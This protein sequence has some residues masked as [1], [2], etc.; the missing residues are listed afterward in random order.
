MSEI[1]SIEYGAQSTVSRWFEYYWTDQDRRILPWVFVVILFGLISVGPGL[2]LY[3]VSLLPIDE[4]GNSGASIRSHQL[5]QLI[6]GILAISVS[7]YV[8]VRICRPALIELSQEGIKK[9]WLI[10][11]LVKFRGHL[12]AWSDIST[13]RILRE[14]GTSDTRLHSLAFDTEE[15]RPAIKLSLGDL[16]SEEGRKTLVEVITN[17]AVKA[18]IESE[19]FDALVPQRALSFTEIWLDALSAPP[20]REQLVPLTEGALLDGRY[21]VVKRLGIGGQGTVYLVIDTQT[22]ANVVLKETILPVYADLI[23]RKSALEAFHKEAFALESVKHKNIAKFLGSFVADHRAYLVLDFIDGKT[24]TEIIKQDGPLEP[25]KA[26]AYGIQMCEVLSVLHNLSP[27]LVHRD[28]TPDNL[29]VTKEG[30]LALIDFAVAV[31]GDRES[32]D[33]AGKPSY[34][35]PE[36]FKGKP[37]IQSDVYSLGGTLHYILTGEHPEPL[38]ESWPMLSNDNVSETMNDVVRQ[39]T[40]LDAKERYANVDAVRAA[41]FRAQ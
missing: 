12:L 9:V 36:Q 41:L 10:L 1:V 17:R 31:V 13:I 38:S 26:R 5:L 11:G 24:L 20:K 25:E 8:A 2:L 35:A 27:P 30:D 23:T 14:P 40:K 33:V 3:L 28:F 32:I 16:E 19:V 15:K 39:C 4:L 7:V 6:A 34:M 22:Q 18:S 37:T 21:R 29:M